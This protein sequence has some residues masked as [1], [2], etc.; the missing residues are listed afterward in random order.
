MCIFNLQTSKLTY[1]SALLVIL[2]YFYS[3]FCV[4]DTFKIQRFLF[5]VYSGGQGRQ[6]LNLVPPD[7]EGNCGSTIRSVT[8]GLKNIPLQ[9]EFDLSSLPSDALKF[10]KA[11]SKIIHASFCGDLER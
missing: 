5:I 2:S 3:F 7:S 10:S 1:V 9:D 11:E 4:C 6:Q 8:G